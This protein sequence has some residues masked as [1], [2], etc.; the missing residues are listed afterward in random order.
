MGVKKSGAGESRQETPKQCAAS[1]SCNDPAKLAC[2]NAMC[3]KHCLELGGE[4]PVH[5]P[6]K[7]PPRKQG[8]QSRIRQITC[9]LAK[10]D[11][12]CQSKE[13]RSVCIHFFMG[14]CTYGD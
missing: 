5:D 2:G 13:G 7:P 6:S 12:I 8:V 10:I 14:R 4:C 11:K 9:R 1:M 3:R